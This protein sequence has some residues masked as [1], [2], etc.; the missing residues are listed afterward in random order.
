VQESAYGAQLSVAKS[1]RCDVQQ[2]ELAQL[3]FAAVMVAWN[4]SGLLRFAPSAPGS[5]SCSREVQ[6]SVLQYREFAKECLRW[7]EE[8]TS[9]QDRRHF[10][11]MAKAWMHAAAEVEKSRDLASAAQ[12]SGHSNHSKSIFSRGSGTS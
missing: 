3:S 10:I 9:E 5:P 4:F 1:V 11:D 7:A 12:S 2:S 6:M 8:S